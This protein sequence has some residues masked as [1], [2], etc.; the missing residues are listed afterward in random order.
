M[1]AEIAP[2]APG[3]DTGAS[4]GAGSGRPAAAGRARSAGGVGG[5]GP[6]G[7]ERSRPRARSSRREE[8]LSAAAHLFAE[9]GFRGVGIEQIG[10]AVGISGPG[11]YRHFPSKDAMLVELLVGISQHLLEGAREA[12][13]TGVGAAETLDRLIRGHVAFAL[14]HPELIVIH[15]RDLWSLPEEAAR[16]VRRLQRAYAE[17]WVDVLREARPEL[18]APT[19]RARAHALFGLINSTPHSANDLVRPQMG[20][21]LHAMALGAARS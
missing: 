18:D 13:R 5:A 3:G 9:R 16:E 4:R 15:D 1:S 6:E 2:N 17:H 12:R 10:A 7:P 11:I 14:D 8:L 20:A 21:M 19:A